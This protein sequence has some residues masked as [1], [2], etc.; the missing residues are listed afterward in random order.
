MNIEKIMN[1]RA[2]A[3]AKKQKGATMIEYA[4]LAALISVAAVVV[5]G[6]VGTAI[7]ATF[8]D[9]LTKL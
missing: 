9:I 7:T 3:V 8:T 2:R 1:L 5:L 4:L 6:S